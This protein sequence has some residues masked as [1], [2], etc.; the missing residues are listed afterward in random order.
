M[1]GDLNPYNWAC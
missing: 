1:E